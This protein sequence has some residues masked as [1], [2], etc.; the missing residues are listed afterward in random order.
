MIPAG[1]TTYFS[2]GKFPLCHWGVLVT[3][4]T[5]VDVESLEIE[6]RELGQTDD[7]LGVLWELQR[8]P[9]DKNTVNVVQPFMLSTLKEQWMDYSAKHIG[10]TVMSHDEIQRKGVNSSIFHLLTLSLPDC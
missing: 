3:D 7:R 10:T 9:S 1:V 2:R 5:S 4:S 6:T 8:T